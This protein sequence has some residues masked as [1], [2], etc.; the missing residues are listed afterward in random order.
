MHTK[1]KIIHT[2]LKPENVL[3]CVNESQVN[4]LAEEARNWAKYGTKPCLSAGIYID[5]ESFYIYT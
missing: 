2:D 3:M 4:W 5:F 1:C